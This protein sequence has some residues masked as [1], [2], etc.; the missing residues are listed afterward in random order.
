M[1][2]SIAHYRII[3]QIGAGGMGAVYLAQDTKLDRQVALKILLDQVASDEERVRRFIQEAKAASALN[4]PNIL[5]VYEIGEFE[6]TRY[7]ATELVKGATLRDRL[8]SGPLTLRQV[9]DVTIQ[10]ATALNAAHNAG[11]IHRDIKPENIMIRDDGIVKVLDFGLAK[12]VATAQVEPEEVTRAQVDTLPGVVL[13][14]VQYMS[15]EQTRSKETDARSDIWSLGV[16]IYE[17]LSGT[18]PFAGE[19]SN[20]SIAAI[21]TM[22]PQELGVDVPPELWRV[23]ERA[24]RK[25]VDDRYQAVKDLLVDVKSLKR[26]L[27]MAEKLELSYMPHSTGS[28]DISTNEMSEQAT[29]IHPARISSQTSDAPQHFS[30]A[31]L[32]TSAIRQH[33]FGAMA[34]FAVVAIILAG[35]G[36]GLYRFIEKPQ[37]EPARAP[38]EFKSQRLTGDGKTPDAEVSP[39]GKFLA[40]LKLD[41]GAQS[42]WIKQ[43]QTNSTIPIVRPGDL[44]SFHGITF[45]PDGSF[46]Y[47]SAYDKNGELAVYRAPSLGGTPTKVLVD[48]RLLQFSP[49]GNRVSF[50]R[51]GPGP[52]ETAVF[53]ASADGSNE[54]KVASKA[55]EEF[56]AGSPAW[57]PDGKYIAVGYGNNEFAPNPSTSVKLI[58]VGDNTESD[59]G[60]FRWNGGIDLVWHPSGDSL[61]VS[62]SE[63]SLVP[64]QL[65]EV[66]YPAGSV[67][68][69]T[70][71]QSGYYSISVTSDGR[72]IVTGEAYSRSAVW[73]SPD[74][75]PENAKQVMPATGDTWGF[76]WTPDNRI[77]VASDQTGDNEIW[78]MDADGGNARALTNDRVFKVAP[79]ASPD[80][81]YIVYISANNGRQMERIDIG[82]GNPII[83]DKSV[84]PDNPD[85]STD[86]KWV[87]YDALADGVS[88]IFRVPID[89]GEPERLIDFPGI[90]PHY[91]NDGTKFACFLMGEK[92]QVWTK[93]AVFGADGGPPL[94]VFDLPAGTEV[95]R[96]PVWTPDDRGITLIVAKGETLNLWLQPVQGGDLK[97][98]TN[99]NSPV[100]FR[101]QYSR[102]GKHLAIIRGEGI[103]NAIMITG[104]R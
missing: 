44:T 104:Y 99:F 54:R 12:L 40:Y 35:F 38:A 52:S 90:E 94:N 37:A 89:G 48:A 75:K 25:R 5:T 6:D 66:L 100:L 46:V 19:T 9:L 62:G 70:N 23:V 91:S 15:P 41:G 28:S 102:D 64:A 39:D 47:F 93:L 22:R 18:T 72:S 96:G 27:E 57:S 97:Q 21:L 36:Y 73:V 58:S 8:R 101:R 31:E 92:A 59:L 84:Y 11:I 61:I 43:I 88:R 53:I 51:S 103:G 20:D 68:R 50:L 26:E 14:T 42:L 33:K 24:L 10:V 45:S 76:S 13:G 67:R 85:I 65:F 32:F 1:R 71:S 7:I 49:D 87:I 69:L 81:R 29:A 56:F 16:V 2:S 4:H 60:S 55:G 78:I 34:I 17:M 30:S 86:G 95:Y 77:A 79:V 83:F 3:S 98:M 82:G 80:G 63:N 74:L